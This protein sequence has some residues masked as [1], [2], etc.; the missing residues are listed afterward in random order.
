MQLHSGC[1]PAKT[2]YSLTSLQTWLLVRL[3]YHAPAAHGCQHREST[4]RGALLCSVRPVWLVSTRLSFYSGIFPIP[5]ASTVRT[6][7]LLDVM[8]TTDPHHPPQTAKLG[9]ASTNCIILIV[10]IKGT[11]QQDFRPPV[12]SSFQPAWATDQ[13]VKIFSYLVLFSPRYSNFNCEK[14]DSPGYDTPRSQ[15]K[16]FNLS[17]A[18]NRMQPFNG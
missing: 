9:K 13:W 12:F 3:Q 17:F 14:T 18:K 8:Y 15:K 10:A 11:V 4:T 7:L 5:P 2:L 6:V 16:K 1:I